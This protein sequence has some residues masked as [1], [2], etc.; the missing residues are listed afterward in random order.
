MES[1][2]VSFE[3]KCTTCGAQKSDT[4]KLQKCSKCTSA[5]YCSRTCQ[6]EDWPVHKPRCN[7]I[8]ARQQAVADAARLQALHDLGIDY[9][10]DNKIQKFEALIAENPDIVNFQNEEFQKTTLLYPVAYFNRIRCL[11]NMLEK[12][13][14]A[15]LQN[16]GGTSALHIACQD[17]HKE[18]VKMLLESRANINMQSEQ[19]VTHLYIL[20]VRMIVYLSSKCFWICGKISIL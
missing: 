14:D 9:L 15:N 5:R 2:Q 4:V 8:A 7:E 3:R 6:K 20:H 12:H 10:R 16:T 11:K 19:G 18:I 13:A 17:G 1:S